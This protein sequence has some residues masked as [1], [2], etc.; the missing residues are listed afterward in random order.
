MVTNRLPIF[1]LFNAL[2]LVYMS[3]IISK[4]YTGVYL[5]H[6]A[7]G[8]ISYSITYK[9]EHG[10]LKRFTVGKKSQGITEN[11]ANVKRSEFI[12]KIRLGEDPAAAKK[13][14]K[15]NVYTLDMLAKE[16]YDYKELYNRNNAKNRRTYTAHISPYIGNKSINSICHTD[17]EKIQ[18]DKI[19]AKLSPKYCN[20]IISEI[21]VMYNWAI[22][23]GLYDGLSPSKKVKK[24]KVDNERERFLSISDIELLLQKVEH[25]ELL[26]LFVLISLTTGARENAACMITKKDINHKNWIVNIKD[27]KEE[28]TYRGFL[29]N[30]RLKKLLTKRLKELKE[31]EL[32]LSYYGFTEVKRINQYVRGYIKPILDDLFNTELDVKDRKNR[33]V[34]H[35]LRHTFASHLA[36]NGTPILTIQKLMNHSNILTTMRYAKL[37]PDSGRD[38]IKELYTTHS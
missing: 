8:D 37:A 32:I 18:Q 38:A 34:L 3:R 24:L 20:N 13:K 15:K 9:D 17:I 6:L 2:G 11:Y 19:K 29:E 16:H 22:E 21:S 7:G 10:K 23:R 35:T 25:D 36:I 14:K 33:V 28:K 5:N 4:K 30:D 31:N 27:E 1:E 12:N 26:L